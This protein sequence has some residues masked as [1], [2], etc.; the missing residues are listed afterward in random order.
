MNL[1][2]QALNS[3]IKA[4]RKNPKN[5]SIVSF[6]DDN[7][8]LLTDSCAF[9]ILPCEE[10]TDKDIERI[11]SIFYKVN[12]FMDKKYDYILEDKNLYESQKNLMTF[13]N[14]K[15]ISKY[16][17]NITPKKSKEYNHNGIDLLVYEND[18]RTWYI[19]K[20]YEALINIPKT[21]DKE[22]GLLLNRL[23]STIYTGIMPYRII[24]KDGIKE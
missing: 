11:E 24:E 22:N 9:V 5:K 15:F 7:K 16:E 14:D 23:T 1:K 18:S 20:K 2:K 13:L 6:T 10:L 8:V 17:Y 21:Y 12:V 3:I 4:M 19:D